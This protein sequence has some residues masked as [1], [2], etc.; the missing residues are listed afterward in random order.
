MKKE[1]LENLALIV[2]LQRKERDVKQQGTLFMKGQ[3]KKGC[4]SK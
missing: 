2:H 1:G 4:M 3:E